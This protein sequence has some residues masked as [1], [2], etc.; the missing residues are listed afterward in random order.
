MC[1][2]CKRLEDM[3]DKSL[4]QTDDLIA[5]VKELMAEPNDMDG[6]AAHNTGATARKVLGD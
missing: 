1:E 3:L 5:M 6:I 2:N 4:A